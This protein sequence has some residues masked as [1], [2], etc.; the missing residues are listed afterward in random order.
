MNVMVQEQENSP[1]N[2]IIMTDKLNNNNMPRKKKEEIHA[3]GTNIR[4]DYVPEVKKSEVAITKNF[5]ITSPMKAITLAETV[6][7]LITE[8]KLFS[9]IQG[10][11]FVNV[12]GWQFAGLA[13]G[14]IPIMHE[15]TNLSNEN[16][17]K[18]SASVELINKDGVKM[19]YGYAVCSNKERLKERF[20]EYAIC[21][22]AQTRA[23][24]KAYRN[25]IAWLMK[26]SGFEP[27]PVEE[28]EA[29]KDPATELRECKT[30]EELKNTFLSLDTAQQRVYEK[31]KNQLKEK[32]GK[33]V[34]VDKN[35]Q[36]TQL[37]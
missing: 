30:L 7:K 12:E 26:A 25:C 6:E 31:L 2:G 34:A 14:L 9:L 36:E 27:T 17:V 35:E 28:M 29:R 18:Y 1:M 20:D 24:G 13:F 5:E 11:K 15:P 33:E 22:M 23:I 19:G 21:S 10:K 8:K 16:E 37:P 3:D 4:F 32:L